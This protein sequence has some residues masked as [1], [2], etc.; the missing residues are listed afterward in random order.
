[1]EN[2]KLEL[3]KNGCHIFGNKGNMWSKSAH[4]YKSGRGNLCG[5]PA[6]SFN[7]CDGAIEFL[8]CP[9]CIK[10]YEEEINVDKML[11]SKKESL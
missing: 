2:K 10:I 9:K 7:H 1:M 4:I 11:I 6:L 8:G 3:L 5:T